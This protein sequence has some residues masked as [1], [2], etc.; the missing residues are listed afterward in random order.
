MNACRHNETFDALLPQLHR[1]A[2]R[3]TSCPDEAADLAQEAALRVWQHQCDGTP[4]DNARAYAMTALHNLARSRWRRRQNWAELTEDI[5]AVSPEAPQRIACAELRAALT[6]LP[7]AQADLMALVA[8]GE[9]SPAQLARI[10]G[11]PLGTVM[12]RLARARAAL[13][14]DMGLSKTAPSRLLFETTPE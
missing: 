13:R 5:A 3:L 1:R 4:I 2:R 7:D 14:V 10:T 11:Q 6:R 12:S 8:Q 9:T